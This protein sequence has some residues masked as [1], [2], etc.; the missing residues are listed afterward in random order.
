MLNEYEIEITGVN[1][2]DGG[3]EVFARAWKDGVQLGFGKDGSV[4]IERFRYFNPRMLVDD[5][6]G[7]IVRVSESTDIETGVVT[8]NKR[9]LRYDP[10]EAMKIC[11]L[12]TIKQVGKEGTNIVVV[13]IGNTVT[14]FYSDTGTGSTTVDGPLTYDTGTSGPSWDQA[15]DATDTADSGGGLGGV[16]PSSDGN[17]DNFQTAC[18]IYSA[19]TGGRK[20]I[21][22]AA[23]LFDTS[24]IGTDTVDTA[25]FSI[26]VR[27]SQADDNDGDDFISVV[28]SALSANNNIA[29]TDFDNIGDA[30]DD[31]TEGID[32]GDRKDISAISAT[33]AF[34]SFSLNTTGKGWVDTSGI[35][36]LGTREGHDILDNPITNISTN[37][38]NR[39]NIYF[40]DYA[41]TTSD[42]KLVVEHSAGGGSSFIPQTIII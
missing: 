34:L 41:G 33:P 3:I 22:R 23:Y 20:I 9:V 31:P 27:D 36:K 7:D 39:V 35:T 10:E 14:T 18:T 29:T 4:D 13:K 6:N 28:Q 30:I 26:F 17:V 2:I 24:A 12:D 32:T 5:I 25:T 19:A 21:T 11:L 16:F 37:A 8:T 42:P 15:H 38:Y 40:S 1:E